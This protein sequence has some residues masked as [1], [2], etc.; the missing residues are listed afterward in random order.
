MYYSDPNLNSPFFSKFKFSL[1]LK[2]LPHATLCPYYLVIF[3]F[4][5]VPKIT[6]PLLIL[7]IFYF[8]HFIKD[9]LKCEHCTSSMSELVWLWW[10]S[11]FNSNYLLL[12]PKYFVKAKHW[13]WS[14]LVDF[15]KF[16]SKHCEIL[17]CYR[18]H[19]VCV[20]KYT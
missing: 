2:F 14:K 18:F 10:N 17:N 11:V 19:S 15:T 3:T 7:M 5:I 8:P 16:L 9:C 6:W 4:F 13:F 20:R 12:L 1:K